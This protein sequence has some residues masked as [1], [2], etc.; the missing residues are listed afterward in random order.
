MGIDRLISN[1]TN[2]ENL[3]GT[4]GQPRALF[5]LFFNDMLTF[6][7]TNFILQRELDVLHTNK[8]RTHDIKALILSAPKLVIY[9]IQ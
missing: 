6:L 2:G 8:T 3:V 1:I 4:K 5:A 9:K 7:M